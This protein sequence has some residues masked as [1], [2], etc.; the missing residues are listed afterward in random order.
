MVNTTVNNTSADAAACAYSYTV[1]R[2]DSYYLI[3]Q[4]LGVPLRDLLSANP[5]I[6]PARLTVGDVLCIPA[7]ADVNKPAQCPDDILNQPAGEGPGPVELPTP[8]LPGDE[9]TTEETPPVIDQDR[10]CPPTRQVTVQP[11]QTVS[12]L[13][14]RYGLSLHTL[15]AANNVST[16]E[17]VNAGD[18]LCIPAQNIPCDVPQ[19]V[20]LAQ[21]QTLETTATAYNLSVADLL[22][23][24]PCLAPSDFVE[25]TTVRLPQ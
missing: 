24:N 4:R 14:L 19:T 22:R 7:G 8:A 1:K 9:G 6:A 12:D 16:L 3:S 25:G 20:V 2:G 17:S 21:G 10:L 13:Q 23:A 11:G 18:V 5:D 15:E